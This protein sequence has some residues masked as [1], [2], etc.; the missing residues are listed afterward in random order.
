MRRQEECQDMKYLS[1][2]EV[3][4]AEYIP[5]YYYLSVY[6]GPQKC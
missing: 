3:V 2:I 4:G 1:L 5:G 6:T